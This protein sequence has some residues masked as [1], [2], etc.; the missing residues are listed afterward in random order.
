MIVTD[1][2]QL[3]IKSEPVTSVKDVVEI[4]AKLNEEFI[5]HDNS[6]GLAAVQIGI[7]KQVGSIVTKTGQIVLINPT[8]VGWGNEFVFINEGCMSFPDKFINTKRYGDI[9]ID[10]HVIDG[11]TLR[12]ERQYYSTNIVT[13]GLIPICIQHEIDHMM[14]VLY[15][16]RYT[17][18]KPCLKAE[19][20]IGRNEMCPCRSGKKY[21]K[22]CLK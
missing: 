8:I 5:K 21:K 14:G 19:P 9:V 22:C 18:E 7:P 17:S 16:D 4:L 11:D 10:N 1:I 20:K 2:D 12:L 3:R 15:T 6:C 13:D